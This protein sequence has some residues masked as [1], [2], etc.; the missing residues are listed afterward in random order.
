MFEVMLEYWYFG[1]PVDS[2]DDYIIQTQK[3]LTLEHAEE[4]ARRFLLEAI[5][6]LNKH[7]VEWGVRIS[8][9]EN[10]RLRNDLQN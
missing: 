8:W 9:S 7:R 3:T 1:M 5:N 10:Q 4:I 6:T 2:E